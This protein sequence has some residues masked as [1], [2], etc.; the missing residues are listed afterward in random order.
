VAVKVLNA[1]QSPGVK[2]GGAVNIVTHTIEVMCPVESI[3][4]AIEVD[5]SGLEI[6]HS[7]HISDVTLP[8]NVRVIAQGDI[9]LVTVVPPS[10]Y[11]EEMKAAAE[12]AAA[13]AAAAAAVAAAGAVRGAEG[14]AP[15]AAPGATPGAAPGAAPAATS[16][17][18]AAPAKAEK[19]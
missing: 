16:A 5:I 1:D 4:E 3:P 17:A 9:T 18:A 2:R 15:G 6:N 8:P 11:A 19:K 12:A 7:K 14:A 10:G 13:A